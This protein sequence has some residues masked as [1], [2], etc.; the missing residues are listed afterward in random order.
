MN[1]PCD[2]CQPDELISEAEVLLVKQ[3][4]FWESL[5]KTESENS[6]KG[7]RGYCLCIDIRRKDGTWMDPRWGVSGKL[8]EFTI[9][10]DFLT[11][12]GG[13]ASKASL[14]VA[15]SMVKDNFGGTSSP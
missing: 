12:D 7:C 10:I 14:D 3:K 2:G 8:I 15:E 6:I 13:E 9:D 11:S 5:A 1:A 4:K